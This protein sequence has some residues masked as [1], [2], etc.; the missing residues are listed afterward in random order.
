M[1]DTA[2][3]IRLLARC[4]QV[5]TNTLA[6]LGY[7]LTFGAATSA[8]GRTVEVTAEVTLKRSYHDP[9]TLQGLLD[10]LLPAGA[11]LVQ[12]TLLEHRSASADSLAAL[13]A[14][15]LSELQALCL[16]GCA[17]ACVAPL[18]EF[19]QHVASF[20][21][22]DS[23]RSPWLW[24]SVHLSAVPAA[25][26][27]LPLR[28]LQLR[29]VNLADLPAGRW[30]EG[31]TRCM[32]Q[33]LPADPPQTSC[34]CSSI[35]WC[36]K[37]VPLACLLA[38]EMEE[39]EVSVVHRLP[40]ALA[41]TPIRRLAITIGAYGHQGQSQPPTVADVDNSLLLMPH[42]GRLKLSGNV[43]AAVLQHL[44]ERAPH[45]HLG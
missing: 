5:G 22:T 10:W 39:L 18:L 12:L 19:A 9:G 38:A 25:M 28:R 36:C 34:S 8:T 3:A 7:T 30:L 21:I 15:G 44:R 31:T 29:D 32:V 17:S 6:A 40:A 33:V 1:Q 14:P 26:A 37:S 24:G 41:G 2:L 43:P 4:T 11:A 42:L 13:C 45:V 35:Q 20:S 16:D 27:G 23:H